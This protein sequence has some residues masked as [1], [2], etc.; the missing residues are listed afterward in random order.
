MSAKIR[1]YFFLLVT[2]ILALSLIKNILNYNK[3]SLLYRQIQTEQ[4]KLDRENKQ[5]K[6]E[7]KKNSDPDYTEAKIRQ[8]LNLLK[9]GEM[10]VII[11]T[12]MISPTPNPTPILPV[13]RQWLELF[14]N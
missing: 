6:S 13:Y 4:Q 8:Q 5:L 1:S 9:P 14:L 12:V 3:K 11:P 10:A 7:L 2:L